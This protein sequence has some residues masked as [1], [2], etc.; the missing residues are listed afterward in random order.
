MTV[1]A[2][3]SHYTDHLQQKLD[4]KDLQMRGWIEKAKARSV[5]LRRNFRGL[6]AELAKAHDRIRG[7]TTALEARKARAREM[8]RANR[9]FYT[10]MGTGIKPEDLTRQGWKVD[11][12]DPATPSTSPSLADLLYPPEKP[13]S[14]TS[15]PTLPFITPNQLAQALI[16]KRS[17]IFVTQGVLGVAERVQKF[18]TARMSLLVAK[19]SPAE[20]KD[21]ITA[22]SLVRMRNACAITSAEYNW[23]H[24]CLGLWPQGVPHEVGAPHEA[25]LAYLKPKPK[26]QTFGDLDL[27]PGDRIVFP[28][29]GP[30]TVLS[31]SGQ[32]RGVLEKMWVRGAILTVSDRES[33][34]G[35]VTAEG[36]VDADVQIIRKGA[37]K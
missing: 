19:D 32:T 37:G 14:S 15:P 24:A 28:H 22:L 23:A 26:P 4:A 11:F 33:S 12:D 13:M 17:C 7:L 3:Y 30:C 20:E 25:L 9:V 1:P 16:D 29:I 8:S 35:Y 10:P 27:Q 31:V 5:R 6:K 18:D 36:R 2:Y 21:K 34:L